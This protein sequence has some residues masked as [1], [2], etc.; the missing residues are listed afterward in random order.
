VHLSAAWLAPLAV[1]AAGAAALAAAAARLR[2]E[3]AALQRSMRPL[4]F[5]EPSRK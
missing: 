5:K 2:S 4:R 1:G 3:V